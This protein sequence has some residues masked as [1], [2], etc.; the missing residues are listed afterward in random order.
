MSQLDPAAWIGSV[1]IKLFGDPN[2][3]LSTRSQ[4]RFGNQGSLAVEI[5]GPK[6]GSWYDHERGEGGGTLDLLRREKGLSPA[7]GIKWIADNLGVVVPF[8]RVPAIS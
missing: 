7:D 6:A 4:L 2:Q 3:S 1:A 8:A 5:A